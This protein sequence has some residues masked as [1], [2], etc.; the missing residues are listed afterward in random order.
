MCGQRRVKKAGKLDVDRAKRLDDIGMVWD[1]LSYKWDQRYQLL[2]QYKQRE[3]DCMVPF[4]HKE[5]GENLGSWLDKQRQAK[6]AGKLDGDNVQ[7][8][9]DVGMV[10]DAMSY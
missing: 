4:G 3:G 5:N 6:K 8:L 10:W 1:V 9:E 2:I 7:R